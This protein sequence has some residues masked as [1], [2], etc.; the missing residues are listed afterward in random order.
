MADLTPSPALLRLN[1][2]FSLRSDS[3]I[4]R[5]FEEGLATKGVTKAH[6]RQGLVSAAAKAVRSIRVAKHTDEDR[7]KMIARRRKWAG[8]NTPP[9]VKAH[10]SLAEQAVLGVVADTCKRKGFCDLCLDELARIAGVSRTTV[11]NALRKARSKDLGHVSVRERP[12]QG[13]KSLTNVIRIVCSRW[14]GWITRGIGFKRL[15]TSVTGVKKDLSK[16]DDAKIS[17]FEKVSAAFA[18]KPSHAQRVE[19]LRNEQKHPAP[20]AVYADRFTQAAPVRQRETGGSLWSLDQS[21]GRN[22]L[23][24]LPILSAKGLRDGM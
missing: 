20:L 2:R 1:Q 15:N 5:R 3:A 9:D 7:A 16:P 17:A 10:Y 6:E 23:P 13:R 12:Q 18:R 14:I 22:D 19:P 8:A 11:Q 4:V 21:H 24:D